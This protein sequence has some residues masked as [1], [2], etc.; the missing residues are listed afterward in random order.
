MTIDNF[1][2]GVSFTR[3][4]FYERDEAPSNLPTQNPT[5]YYF[6]SEPTRSAAE[7]GVGSFRTVSSWTELLS[8]PYTRSWSVP[9]INDPDP[10][11]TTAKKTYWEAINILLQGSAAQTQ[12]ILRAFDITRP[13]ATD[14]NADITVDSLKNFYPA[15]QRYMDD[16]ELGELIP[17]ALEQI[18]K[19]LKKK[20]VDW[21]KLRNQSEL[22]L[23]LTYKTIALQ[24]LGSI[25]DPQDR[26]A[27][28]FDQF[29]KWYNEEIASL[30]LQYDSDGDGAA[31]TTTNLS[32]NTQ[33][34][35]R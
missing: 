31:D 20:N 27:F 5:I 13:A 2:W 12:C 3:Q 30:V 19:D 28:R 7:Y 22:N 23:A 25:R 10:T 32:T 11:G 9:P 17:I 1:T 29:E 8:S 4:L 24:S 16:T 15:I 34:L 18:R 21:Y 14:D 26:H 6:D 33:V 35:S